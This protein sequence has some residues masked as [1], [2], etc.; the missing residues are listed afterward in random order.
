MR[1]LSR[2]ASV[3]GYAIVTAVVNLYR[4]GTQSASAIFATVVMLLVLNGFLLLVSTLNLAIQA[5]EQKVNVI[6]Y[7]KED[8]DDETGEA[9]RDR[10]GTVGSVVETDYLSRA[11]AM[12]RL[13]EQLADRAELLN[14]VSGNPLPASVEVRVRDASEVRKVAEI[15]RAEQSV[16]EVAVPEDAVD[17]LVRL[18]QAAR[19]GGAFTIIGFAG[20]TVVVIGNTIRLAVY[21]RRQEIELM[22][23]VGATDWFI[24]WPFVIEGM[25]YGIVGAVIV[26]AVT[27]LALG[28]VQ[29]ALLDVL[30]FL[31]IRSDPLL[32]LQLLVVTGFVGVGV[33]TVGSYVSVRRFLDA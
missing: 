7:L 6:A 8:V 3:A 15:L 18:A 28:T 9:L 17:S 14:M 4:H 24:R 32:P 10:I 1:Q 5:L 21:A 13:R 29:G 31:P 16:D 2:M 20:V 30:K 22:R 33:G 27:L 11:A 19:F 25:L 12:A 26:G 23:L